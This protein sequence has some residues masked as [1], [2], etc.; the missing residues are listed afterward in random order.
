MGKIK[1]K[2][3]LLF[4]FVKTRA[5]SHFWGNGET[6]TQTQIKLLVLLLFILSF[7]WGKNGEKM[8]K[9]GEKISG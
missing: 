4:N 3:R 8:G 2:N 7:M 9:R 5:F 1:K 6:I